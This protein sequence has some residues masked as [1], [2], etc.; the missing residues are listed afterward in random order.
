M[1]GSRPNACT[2]GPR[3]T[4]ESSGARS[5]AYR[6]E[7]VLDGFYEEHLLCQSIS[8]SDSCLMYRVVPIGVGTGPSGCG[9]GREKNGQ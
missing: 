5:A 4:K 1:S 2:A 7:L 8:Q 9:A 6:S 3:P